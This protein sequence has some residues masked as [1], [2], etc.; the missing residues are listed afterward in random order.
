MTKTGS[1]GPIDAQVKIGRTRIS[2]SDYVDW[3]EKK[4]EE[5]EKNNK[6]NPFDAIVIAQITPGELYG[7][8]HGLEYA[9]DWVIEW[10]P[11]YKFKNWNKTETRQIV[12]TEEMKKERA[13]VIADELIRRKIWRTHGRPI[14]INDLEDLLKINRVEDN[15]QLS[16]VVFRIHTVM[17]FLFD[18][19][20]VFKI[21][22]T[23]DEKIF[24]HFHSPIV[25]P[26]PGPGQAPREA[27][28]VIIDHT[29]KNCG[30]V[31]NL[32]AKLK[33]DPKIDRDMKGQGRTPF[34]MNNLITCPCAEKIDLTPVRRDI[35]ANTG[36]KMVF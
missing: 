26:A 5:A 28:T 25:Q 13:K 30:K 2:A 8:V 29:C 36:K 7:V 24:R 35:E 23:A 1:L 6:L 21:F 22:A 16:D 12:V 18:R 9:K 32:Y 14:K 33:K 27:N 17:R 15:P 11:K 31:H 34:P 20:T 19:S 4:R 10:I 3:V